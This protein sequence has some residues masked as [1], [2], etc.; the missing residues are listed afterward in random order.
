MK[1]TKTAYMI[2]ANA[3]AILLLVIGLLSPLT[4][5]EGTP[6][7][8]EVAIFAGGPLF[9]LGVMIYKTEN[10]MAKFIFFTEIAIISSMLF[11]VL[12]AVYKYTTH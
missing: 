2:I 3:F 1:N 12:N 6:T 4:P 8:L 10:R 7:F 5:S 9:I 11:W